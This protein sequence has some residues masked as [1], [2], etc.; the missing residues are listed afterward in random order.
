MKDNRSFA[1]STML[2]ALIFITI[3]TFYMIILI[4]STRNDTNTD[5]VNEIRD[6]LD[7]LKIN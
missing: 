3:A 5:F 4:V 1:I 2:Y 7:T 6:Q